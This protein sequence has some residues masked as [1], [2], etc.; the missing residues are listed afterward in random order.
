MTPLPFIDLP[1]PKRAKPCEDIRRN[2]KNAVLWAR[3]YGFLPKEGVCVKCTTRVAG[4]SY[5]AHHEDYNLPRRVTMLCP[6]CH[7]ER[8]IELGWGWGTHPQNRPSKAVRFTRRRRKHGLCARCAKPS[9]AFRCAECMAKKP[10]FTRMKVGRFGLS[11]FTVL[12]TAD[13]ESTMTELAAKAGIGTSVITGIID[14]LEKDGLVERRRVVGDRRRFVI[15]RTIKGDEA[16]RATLN[17]N[18]KE[19]LKSA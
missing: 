6:G 17:S 14:G 10:E 12:G 13:G 19:L 1:T 18:K 2:S 11:A 15:A 16:L 8:H 9:E 4:R 5:H 7:R 3:K